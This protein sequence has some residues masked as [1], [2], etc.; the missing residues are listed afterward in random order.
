MH[1]RSPCSMPGFCP[2][3]HNGYTK[4]CHANPWDEWV[5]SRHSWFSLN[6]ACYHCMV[7]SHVATCCKMLQ[8]HANLDESLSLRLQRPSHPRV[9][10]ES[11]KRVSRETNVRQMTQMENKL[12]TN[13]TRRIRGEVLVQNSG[14]NHFDQRWLWYAVVNEIG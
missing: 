2:W 9:D 11:H 5:T 4:N 6:P 14:L 13:E 8:S 3:C 1:P 12:K 10:F 7:C